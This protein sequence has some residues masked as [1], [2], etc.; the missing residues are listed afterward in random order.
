MQT[1]PLRLIA[2]FAASVAG[3]IV[4]IGLLPRTSGFTSALPTIGCIAALVFS[5]WM[6]A[7]IAYSGVTLGFLVP[8]MTTCVPLAVIAM[9]IVIY[10]ESASLMRVTIL[11]T[12]CGLV[13]LAAYVS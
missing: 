6:A 3:Q 11:V 13:G 8:L 2:F 1:L 5:T 12:A 4:A 7:R 9:G 10:G